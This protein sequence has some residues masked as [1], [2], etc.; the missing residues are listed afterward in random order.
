M[1]HLYTRTREWFHKIRS[2]CIS[3]THTQYAELVL[4]S[5]AFAESFIFPIPPDIVLIPMVFA[6]KSYAFRYALG[7]TIASVL[8]GSIGYGIGFF[9]FSSLG[10]WII[11][12]YSLHAIYESAHMWFEK[13]GILTMLVAGITPLPYKLA[14]ILAGVFTFSFPLFLVTSFIGRGIRFFII[15]FLP[16]VSIVKKIQKNRGMLLLFMI[17]LLISILLLYTFLREIM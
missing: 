16:H 7:T 12:T 9:F 4:Y 6:R 8:G 17:V 1:I 3:Y 13:Y 14:T 5:I 15:A 11:D 10:M 2:L